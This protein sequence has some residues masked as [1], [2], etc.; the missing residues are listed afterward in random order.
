MKLEDINTQTLKI[1]A[2]GDCVQE[3]FLGGKKLK[4]LGAGIS[5]EVFAIPGGD[6]VVKVCTD[7]D[8]DE[9][10]AI[11]E[12]NNYNRLDAATRK[13][14]AKIYKVFP[15]HPQCE[16]GVS[17]EFP[18]TVTIQKRVN[19]DTIRRLT[20]SRFSANLESQYEEFSNRLESLGLRDINM[21]NVMVC[22]KTKKLFAVDLGFGF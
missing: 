12:W 7:S 3:V 4:F 18:F 22:K 5:R 21:S 6:Y 20:S 10:Q 15:M 13:T 14:V 16:K 2:E 11:S 8:E 17:S 1:V 9:N 19:G